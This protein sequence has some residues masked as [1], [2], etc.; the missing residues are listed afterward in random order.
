M[1]APTS[2]GDSRQAG[3]CE[4]KRSRAVHGPHVSVGPSLA[5]TA[6]GCALRRPS[7]TF[8]WTTAFL[9]EYLFSDRGTPKPPPPTHRPCDR[10]LSL[11]M[12]ADNAEPPLLTRPPRPMCRSRSRHRGA[13]RPQPPGLRPQK[14]TA[15]RAWPARWPYAHNR[16]FAP[17]R[18]RWSRS[19]VGADV[20][21]FLHAKPTLP[22]RGNQGK[23]HS[24]APEP[25]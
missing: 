7:P 25:A 14:R 21:G 13:L 23:A 17:G 10:P 24:P 11:R 22:L 2:W 5:P 9:C 4:T 3:V 8:P 20:L 16:P 15:P 6:S 19:W 1:G 12:T 18:R